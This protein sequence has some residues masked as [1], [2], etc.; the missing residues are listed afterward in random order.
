MGTVLAQFGEAV[1]ESETR[2]MPSA[3]VKPVSDQV[4]D[5]VPWAPGGVEGVQC[6]LQPTPSM[7]CWGSV[8]FVAGDAQRVGCR[9]YHALWCSTQGGTWLF[10]PRDRA[11]RPGGT[12]PSESESEAGVGTLPVQQLG[13]TMEPDREK[14][15][16][17]DEPEPAKRLDGQVQGLERG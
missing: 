15:V 7:A 8:A 13:R 17:R 1:L 11:R 2:A 6:A 9:A 4:W 12:A 5:L 10:D 16:E 14:A 3:N